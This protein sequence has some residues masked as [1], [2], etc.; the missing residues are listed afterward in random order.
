MQEIIEE[1]G[2]SIV[3]MLA[4]MGFVHIL[5]SFLNVIVN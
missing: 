4:G 5:M 2:A 1:F 3:F